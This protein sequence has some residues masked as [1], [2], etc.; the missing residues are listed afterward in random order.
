LGNIS[1]WAAT[2]GADILW[3]LSADQLNDDRLGRALEAFFDQRHS[4]LAAVT[5][6]ALRLT[7][8]TWGR[9]HVDTTHL[10]FYGAYEASR[11]R[12]PTA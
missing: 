2:T 4:V 10:V 6:Q 11:P 12:P 5:A 9:L 7:A 1:A 3:G 8:L